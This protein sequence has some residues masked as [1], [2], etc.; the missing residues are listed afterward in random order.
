MNK[1]KNDWKNEWM[2]EWIKE[3]KMGLSEL[4]IVNRKD[5]GL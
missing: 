2:K 3:R 4:W 5:T 1:W